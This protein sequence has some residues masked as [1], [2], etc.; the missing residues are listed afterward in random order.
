MVRIATARALPGE[1]PKEG[2]SPN[3]GSLEEG[4]EQVTPLCVVRR[5]QSPQEAQ[6]GGRTRPSHDLVPPGGRVNT[7]DSS[8]I[9]EPHLPNTLTA[10]A[11]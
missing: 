2:A 8:V 6:G 9:N 1:A 5:L 4:V 11:R 10:I 3:P 7:A